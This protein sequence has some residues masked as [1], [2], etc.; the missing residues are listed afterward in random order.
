MRKPLLF[1]L[2]LLSTAVLRAQSERAVASRDSIPQ[3]RRVDIENVVITGA[4]SETDL[5]HL[6]MTVSVV[7]RDK[8]ESG[9]QPSRC[10]RCLPS[11]CR[12]CS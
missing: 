4:R 2:F 9:R 11:R 6:P 8:I 1:M 12:V 7:G 3:D 5:R 10:F